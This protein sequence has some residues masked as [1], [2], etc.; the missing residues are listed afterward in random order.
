MS[1]QLR[2][3]ID[4]SGLK[5]VAA[6]TCCAFRSNSDNLYVCLAASVCLCVCSSVQYTCAQW[7][8]CEYLDSS[9]CIS[10]CPSVHLSVSIFFYCSLCVFIC[11]SVWLPARLCLS[12]YLSLHFYVFL[13]LVINNPSV[14]PSVYFYFCPS[15][16]ICLSV[17]RSVKQSVCL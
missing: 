14:S 7:C 8:N 15:F 2:R 5:L 6:P 16:I 13:P 12:L 10:I 9:V 3:S 1:V 11:M 4:R 17:R